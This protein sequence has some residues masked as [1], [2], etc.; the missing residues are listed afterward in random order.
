MFWFIQDYG[1]LIP[2][3]PD[4]QWRTNHQATDVTSLAPTPPP[5]FHVCYDY[6]GEHY[7]SSY[8]FSN[9]QH[10]LPKTSYIFCKLLFPYNLYYML[11]LDDK[12][13]NSRARPTYVTQGRCHVEG[14][15]PRP[16]GFRLWEK[17]VPDWYSVRSR[18]GV[19]QYVPT[20]LRMNIISAI[21]RNSYIYSKIWS[22]I[23]IWYKTYQILRLPEFLARKK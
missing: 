4:I 15:R 10:Y 19:D 14:S 2:H 1:V 21:P 6:I 9:K 12:I 11:I 23:W 7:W 8:W 16:L 18:E 20:L 22:F 5:S 3:H 17:K 13:S